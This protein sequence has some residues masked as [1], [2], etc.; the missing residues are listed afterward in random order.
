MPTI[1]FPF[2]EKENLDVVS[3]PY[4]S[5][6]TVKETRKKINIFKIFNDFACSKFLMENATL[7]AFT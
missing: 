6:L 4:A 7:N 2:K 5:N 1:Y 3:T